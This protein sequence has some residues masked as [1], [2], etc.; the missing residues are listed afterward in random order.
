[1][2]FV[3]RGIKESNVPLFLLQFT[4][5]I[6]CLD[7]ITVQFRPHGLSLEGIERLVQTEGFVCGLHAKSL[8]CGNIKWSVQHPLGNCR[9]CETRGECCQVTPRDTYVITVLQPAVRHRAAW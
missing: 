2:V 6:R 5:Q 8:L 7:L 4:V 9:K 3:L 1:M